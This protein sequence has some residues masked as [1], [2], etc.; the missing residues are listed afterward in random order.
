MTLL[1]RGSAG[2]RALSVTRGSNAAGGDARSQPAKRNRPANISTATRR[3]AAGK[4]LITVSPDSATARENLDA[5]SNRRVGHDRRRLLRTGTDEQLLFLRRR[6]R[7]P[8][9]A[10]T[11]R[12]AH[13]FLIG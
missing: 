9:S 6:R 2:C 7:R 12:A 5:Y 11:G 13:P 3:P 4:R 8:V 1:T 10:R